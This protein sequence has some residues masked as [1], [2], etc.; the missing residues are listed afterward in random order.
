MSTAEKEQKANEGMTKATDKAQEILKLNKTE[1][2]HCG[3]G[4]TH[5]CICFPLRIGIIVMAVLCYINTILKIVNIVIVE[6]DALVPTI[7]DLLFAIIASGL[8]IYWQVKD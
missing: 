5:C 3:P 7:L 8:Y 1:C 2:I 6:G 4:M